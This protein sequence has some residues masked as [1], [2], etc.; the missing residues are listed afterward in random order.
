MAA[1]F[2]YDLAFDPP[3]P[4]V[5]L[6]I[7][8]PAAEAGVLVAALV[9]TGADCTI[10]PPAVARRLRLPCVGRLRIAGLGGPVRSVPVFAA[11]IELPGRRWRARLA[12]F[13]GE[14]ILGRDLLNDC[15]A[16]LDGPG[17]TVTLTFGGSSLQPGTRGR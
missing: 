17:Q 3:A 5:S 15:V 11:M 8:A 9:D 2:P 1:R 14:V 16:R 10:I 6:R 13:G 7:A 12:A 4:V